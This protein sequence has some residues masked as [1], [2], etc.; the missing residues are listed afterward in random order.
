MRFKTELC[1]DEALRGGLQSHRFSLSLCRHPTAVS[2][3]DVTDHE[4]AVSSN[5]S[6]DSA[7][8]GGHEKTQPDEEVVIS[9]GEKARS[10]EATS[11]FLSEAPPE[12]RKMFVDGEES[13]KS[14]SIIRRRIWL[15]PSG[16][17][18]PEAAGERG[19]GE[20]E[21][22]TAARETKQRPPYGYAVSWWAGDTYKAVMPDPTKPIGGAMASSKLEVHREIHAVFACSSSIITPASP[23]GDASCEAQRQLL[24]G[25][26]VADP[27]SSGSPVVVWCRYYTMWHRFKPL[28]LVCE[29][30]APDGA[31]EFLGKA[32]L[33]CDLEELSP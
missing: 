25:L 31:G 4:A 32:E 10:D 8:E 24:Q 14:V 27:S 1:K 29:V 7:Q 20:A 28:A 6:E 13:K 30:F 18:A 23:A 15:K 19:K 2:I 26:G 16:Q 33:D 3:I 22:G 9:E 11:A 5:H 21:A 12:V 17:E